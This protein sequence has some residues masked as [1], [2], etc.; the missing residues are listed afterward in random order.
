MNATY[1]SSPARVAALGRVEQ[2][3]RD[4]L[5]RGEAQLRELESKLADLLRDRDVIEEDRSSARQVVDTV[6][7]DVLLGRRA[8][9]RIEEGRFGVC[10]VCGDPIPVERLE[11]IPTAERC[12]R[13]V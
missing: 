1:V 13:C 5:R 4:Q 2:Q 6:R 12:G 11:A 3:L 7:A 8:L 10:S 9:A